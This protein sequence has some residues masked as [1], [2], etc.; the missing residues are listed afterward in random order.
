MLKTYEKRDS[1]AQSQV[2]Y[3][4]TLVKMVRLS[5]FQSVHACTCEAK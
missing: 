1:T 4:C 5:F 2:Q 3:S